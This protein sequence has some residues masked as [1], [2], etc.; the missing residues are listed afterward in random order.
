MKTLEPVKIGEIEVA[1]EAER[2]PDGILFRAKHDG[3]VREGLM[4]MQANPKVE[5]TPE[6]HKLDVQAFVENLAR[7][8]AEHH[9]KEKILDDF[10]KDEKS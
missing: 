8:C 4:H 7:E 2:H 9:K 3:I 10:F 1:I 6:Q 5:R